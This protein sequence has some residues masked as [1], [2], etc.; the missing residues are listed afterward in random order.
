MAKTIIKHLDIREISGVTRP[1]QEGAKV[2]ITKSRDNPKP[3]ETDVDKKYL[4]GGYEGTVIKRAI[5][6]SVVNGH[7]HIIVGDRLDDDDWLECYPWGISDSIAGSTSWARNVQP[8]SVY[9]GDWHEHSWGRNKDDNTFLL[10]TVGD[11]THEASTETTVTE[12][13]DFTDEMRTE[14]A[15]EGSA[16]KDGSFPIANPADL[17][18]AIKAWDALVA[19]S[20]QS[21]VAKHIVKRAQALDAI[22]QIP[23]EGDFAEKVGNTEGK[24]SQT[25]KGNSTMDENE[26]KLDDMQK[27]LTRQG[28]VIALAPSSREYFDGLEKT[29]DQD[30]FL[31]KSAGDQKSIV[32][33]AIAKAQDSDP[34]E[35]T[36]PDG[37]EMRKSAG[38]TAIDDAKRIDELTRKNAE[39]EAERAE[40][41]VQKFVTE[42]LPNLPGD[43]A[44]KMALAKAAFGIEDEDTRKKSLEALEAQ[45]TEMAKAFATAGVSTVPETVN[46][47]DEGFDTLVKAHMETHKVPEAEAILAVSK[48]EAGA[49]AYAASLNDNA[50]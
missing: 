29:E 33:A 47:G 25:K 44:A 7:S 27:Q 14:L 17:S 41:V 30:A 31:E 34:V 39:Y 9:D 26:K 49:V 36:R 3:K 42:K 2:T 10:T 43:N 46:K 11:H 4:D 6:T 22:Q 45:N 13:Y 18:E 28:Q 37:T 35:Y 50:A 15:E 20:D 48:T 40:G 24:L 1:A 16:M 5:L 32:D 19:K 23:T 12:K 38:Q 21:K 8:G